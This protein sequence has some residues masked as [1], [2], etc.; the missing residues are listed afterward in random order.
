MNG[1]VSFFRSEKEKLLACIRTLP[2]NRGASELFGTMKA[3]LENEGNI[4]D[5]F[6]IAIAAIAVSHCTTLITANLAHF[7]RIQG[8]H[9][10]H[11]AG[12]A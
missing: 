11:W 2:W 4:I 1:I 6:D 7:T 3:A 10:R 8:L 12:E 5:D 9:V